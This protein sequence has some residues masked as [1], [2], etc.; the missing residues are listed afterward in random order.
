VY[1]SEECT[2][3]RL[4]LG[5][6]QACV[7]LESKDKEWKEKEWKALAAAGVTLLPAD[8][9]GSRDDDCPVLD[10]KRPVHQFG[11]QHFLLCKSRTAPPST[12]ID[13][14]KL[15]ARDSNEPLWIGPRARRHVAEPSARLFNAAEMGRLAECKRLIE[16]AFANVNALGI[17]NWIPLHFA[18]RSGHAPVVN[19]L[20]KQG[21][22]IDAVT[23]A[24]WSALHFACD[25]GH[26]DV[27]EMLLTCG[28][29]PNL[30][31]A[32]TRTPLYYA[33]QKNFAELVDLLQEFGAGN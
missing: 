25:R 14:S 26:R 24:R 2:L 15:E 31:N 19:Y 5:I 8:D 30:R 9:K 27:A 10:E 21:A 1:I 22:L 20:L 13:L 6:L 4:V 32:E 16:H 18:A 7:R 28:A 17:D 23:K 3:Q 12:P 29:D 33:R 11:V